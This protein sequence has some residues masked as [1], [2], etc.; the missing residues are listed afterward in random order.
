MTAPPR[1]DV[2]IVNWNTGRYLRDCLDAIAMASR[3]SYVLNRVVVVDNGSTDDSL[4]GLDEVSLPLLILRNSTNRGFAAACNQAASEGDGDFILFLNPDT[5]VSPDALERTMAFMN[6]PANAA[7]GICGGK[8]IGQAG[9]E[10]FSCARFPTLWMFVA[11]M[12]GLAALFP[13]RVP[14]QRVDAGELQGSGVVD[15]VIGA[16]FLIRRPLFESLGGFDERF[17]VYWEDVDLAYRARKAGRPSY[18][19][20]EATVY[21]LGRVSS[22]QIPGKR[23]FYSLRGRSEYARKHWPRWQA[24]LLGVLTLGIELPVR[25]VRAAGGGKGEER[26]AVREAASRYAGYLRSRRGASRRSVG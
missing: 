14:R 2:V 7:I 16:Y 18:Y 6:E 5:Q 23:L 25:Y 24:P 21:H 3:S 10:E 11:K 12:T 1:L 9:N 13:G 17:F 4:D 20:E 26:L 8:T 22:D 15:Q 19:L